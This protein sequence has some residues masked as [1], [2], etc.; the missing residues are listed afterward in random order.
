MAQAEIIIADDKTLNG[1]L[2]S[3]EI[4][5]ELGKWWEAFQHAPAGEREGMLLQDDM[6]RKRRRSRS[7]KKSASGNTG[8]V[9]NTIVETRE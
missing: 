3:G 6:P 7:R 9:D 2:E 4:D 1:M 8:G 5:M